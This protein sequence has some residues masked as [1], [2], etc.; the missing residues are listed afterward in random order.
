MGSS[1]EI[2]TGMRPSRV[3]PFHPPRNS[4]VVIADMLNMLMY[5]ARKKNANRM[6]EYSVWNPPTSSCS[7]STMSNGALF[8]SATP[9]MKKITKE[10]NIG[11]MF[12]RG[13]TIRIGQPNRSANDPDCDATIFWICL[14]YTSDAADDLL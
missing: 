4:V 6:L 3:G 10:M 2:H 14:L 7:A 11:M 9:A 13:M 8:V 1:A 5:S 12:H